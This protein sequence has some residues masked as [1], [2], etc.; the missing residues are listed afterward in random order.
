MNKVELHQ[1]FQW[2]CDNCGVE[3][4]TRG[5]TIPQEQLDEIKDIDMELIEGAWMMAPTNVK[6]KECESQYE[7]EES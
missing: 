2:D 4:F 5:I 3:N 7:T 6:C 1:A